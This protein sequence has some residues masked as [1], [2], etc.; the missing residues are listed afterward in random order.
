M[1]LSHLFRG[2]V[3]TEAQQLLVREPPIEVTSAVSDE[4]DASRSK[5]WECVGEERSRDSRA[6]APLVSDEQ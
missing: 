2:W 1:A 6:P 5:K 4:V 3:E